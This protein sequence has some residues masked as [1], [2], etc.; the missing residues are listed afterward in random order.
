MVNLFKYAVYFNSLIIHLDPDE[1]EL[2]LVSSEPYTSQLNNYLNEKVVNDDNFDLIDW[3][4]SRQEKYPQLFQLFIKYAFIPATSSMVESEF[5]Y[6]GLVI[7]NRRNRIKPE[8]VNDIMIARN[9]CAEIFKTMR[10]S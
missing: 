8:N 5:S 1:S 6:T 10:K 2:V 4:E 7:T 3:W 9:S